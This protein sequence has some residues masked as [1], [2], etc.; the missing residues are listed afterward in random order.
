MFVYK[1]GINVCKCKCKL[2][3]WIEIEEE[4]KLMEYLIVKFI[5]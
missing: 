2:R 5:L 1:R 4:I 3:N